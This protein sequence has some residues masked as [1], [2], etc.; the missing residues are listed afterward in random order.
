PTMAMTDTMTA[1]KPHLDR[2]L[3]EVA[4]VEGAAGLA[5]A[6]GGKVVC[7]DLFD[8]PETCRK[9]W[10]RVMSGLIL[11]A[12]EEKEAAARVSETEVASALEAL[13]SSPWKP[14]RPAGAGEE[15][16]AETDRWHGSVLGLN[17]RLVHGS[18]VASA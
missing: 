13:R 11:D 3:A 1:H 9:V 4:Y 7:V 6:V 18:L 10:P 5:V 16:R 8:S 17:G 2:T 12:L 15:E 14:V